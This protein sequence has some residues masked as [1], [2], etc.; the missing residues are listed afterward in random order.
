MNT[1]SLGIKGNGYRITAYYVDDKILGTLRVAKPSDALYEGNPFSLVSNLAIA[2]Q[3]VALGFCIYKAEEFTFNFEVNGKRRQIEEVGYLDD[4]FHF[5]EV[6][7]AERDK[8]L[9]AH[10][11]DLEPLTEIRPISNNQMLI[12]EVEEFKSGEL[13]V[14]LNSLNPIALPDITL[15]L[16]DLDYN[17]ELSRAVYG[18][19]LSCGIEKDIR[20]LLY[21]GVRYEFES[22]VHSGFS[23][24]FY[25]VKRKTSGIWEMEF[26]S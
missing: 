19:N 2:Y 12:V 20:Y 16:V 14:Q 22:E 17:T 10:Y 21:D 7:R 6:F 26:L 18:Q 11:E 24:S 25:L 15:G 3:R 5:E 8:S 13:S 9:L 4:G 1:A 23:S